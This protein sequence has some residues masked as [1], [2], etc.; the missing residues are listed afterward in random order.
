[1]CRWKEE[2]EGE[3]SHWKERLETSEREKIDAILALKKK[4]ESLE[5][6]KANEIAKLQETHRYIHVQC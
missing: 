4:M 3:A 6:A 1:M 2:L 5:I